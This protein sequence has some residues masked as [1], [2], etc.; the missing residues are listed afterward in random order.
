MVDPN[1]YKKT[2][3]A[4]ATGVTVVLTGELGN[5]YAMTA[6]AITS[7]SLDPVLLL[8]CVGKEANM[9]EHIQMHNDFSV[10]I[11]RE[12]QEDYS[13]YFAGLWPEDA[14]QPKFSFEAR[15]GVPILNNCLAQL[16][17]EV[18]Q[19]YDG[20]DHYIVIGEVR[21]VTLPEEEV[22]PLIYYR[23]TYYHQLESD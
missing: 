10:N 3:G 5:E 15:D 16:V 9:I 4:F 20:G 12:D 23:G 22:T 11:L 1:D 8:V 13:I 18:Y 17:C 19:V 2:I 21:D 7:L 6:N 14:P